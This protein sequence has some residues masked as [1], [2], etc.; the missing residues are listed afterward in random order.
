MS[1]SSGKPAEPSATPISFEE[2]TAMAA[3]LDVDADILEELYP[4]VRDL[5]AFADKMN[6]LAPELGQE[7]DV[8]RLTVGVGGGLK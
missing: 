5:L 1:E 2:F 7:I 3:R 6:V 4:M 8:A